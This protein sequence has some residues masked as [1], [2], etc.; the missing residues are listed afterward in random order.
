MMNVYIFLDQMKQARMQ[1][2][3]DPNQSNVDNL[4]NVRLEASRHFRNKKEEYLKAK[5]DEFE[6]DRKIKKY[7]RPCIGA[8][9]ILTHSLP[10]WTIVD[11]IIHA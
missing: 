3:Q 8:S 9:M 2:L 5:I 6:N 4:N 11:L 7:Q 10:K 1:Q